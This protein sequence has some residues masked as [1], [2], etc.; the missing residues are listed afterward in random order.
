[1][2]EQSELRKRLDDLYCIACE[3]AR[4][5][6][7][8]QFA[9][10]VD[11]PYPTIYRLVNDK[12][13]VT[14]KMIRRIEYELRNNGIVLD[15]NSNNNNNI[16]APIQQAQNVQQVTAQEVSAPVTQTNS[17]DRWFDLVAEKDAQINRLLGIIEKMQ[18]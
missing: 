10:L 4:I 1:M 15:S 18:E 7:W 6:S 2:K 5:T 8:P 16:V 9:K 11:I 17:D 13:P 3:Q 14:D 12:A